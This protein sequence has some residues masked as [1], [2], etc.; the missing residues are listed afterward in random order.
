MQRLTP[1][2]FKNRLLRL[3]GDSGSVM[4]VA[5]SKAALHTKKALVA[6]ARSRVRRT[7]AAR[8]SWVKYVVEGNPNG[9]VGKL[10]PRG[11]FA[12]LAELGSYKKPGGYPIP[13]PGRRRRRRSRGWIGPFHHPPIKPQ[14]WWASGWD[15][16][17]PGINR[18]YYETQ[19]KEVRKH[20]S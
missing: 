17:K 4:T 11:G 16:A 8:P 14:P 1:P 9:A 20:F 18:I 6:T 3:G 19:V 12:Y 13:R 5:T 15:A 2:E 10:Y 7:P